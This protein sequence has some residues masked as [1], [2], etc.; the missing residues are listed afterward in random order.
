MPVYQSGIPAA[1][2]AIPDAAEPESPRELLGQCTNRANLQEL[3]NG[4]GTGNWI[5]VL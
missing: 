3:E 2:L 4:V 5:P 1:A